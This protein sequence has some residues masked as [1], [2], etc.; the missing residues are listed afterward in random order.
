MYRV[1][2]NVAMSAFGI[3]HTTFGMYPI[4]NFCC[5][6]TLDSIKGV[7]EDLSVC[8]TGPLKTTACGKVISY[9]LCL[10]EQY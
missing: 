6:S 10:V 5:V 9:L 2:T 7:Q 4:F 1:A 3:T 8:G